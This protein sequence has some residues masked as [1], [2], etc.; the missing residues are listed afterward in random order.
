MF[1][2]KQ[3]IYCLYLSIHWCRRFYSAICPDLFC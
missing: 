1:N 3:L 2:F